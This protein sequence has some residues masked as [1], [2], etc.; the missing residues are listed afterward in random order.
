[1]RRL[2]T[3]TA[4]LLAGL[5]AHAETSRNVAQPLTAA[6]LRDFKRPI[7]LDSPGAASSYDGSFAT[8]ISIP[9]PAARAGFKPTVAFS[10]N[11]QRGN[12]PYARGWDLSL[13]RII[14]SLSGGVPRYFG[15]GASDPTTEDSFDFSSIAG[16]SGRLVRVGSTAKGV[17]YRPER[18]GLFAKFYWTS[19][20]AWRVEHLDGR[21]WEMGD[22]D[23]RDS[24]GT[25]VYGWY[26]KRIRDA[27]GNTIEYAYQMRHG[28]LRINRI[29]Y[30]LH[31]DLSSS[32]AT[33]PTILFNW[34]EA[35]G[36][37]IV[38]SYRK[39]FRAE[40]DAEYISSITVVG[41]SET[42]AATTQTHVLHYS[43]QSGA[44]DLSPNTFGNDPRNWRLLEGVTPHQG[45]RTTFTYTPSNVRLDPQAEYDVSCPTPENLGPG[46]QDLRRDL[47]TTLRRTVENKVGNDWIIREVSRLVDMDGDGD[48]DML[49]ARCANGMNGS[50]S[51]SPSSGNHECSWHWRELQGTTWATTDNSVTMPFNWA[52][53]TCT[54]EQ[55]T[56]DPCRA[57]SLTVTVRTK[58][59]YLTSPSFDGYKATT[60]Q[61][62]RD[63]NGDGLSDLVYVEGVER[64]LNGVHATYA[65]IIVCPNLGNGGFGAC[66][67]WWT[68]PRP[69]EVY[70]ELGYDITVGTSSQ[71]WT[72][73]TFLDFDGDG[74]LDYLRTDVASPSSWF[75]HR[76][77]PASTRTL[78]Q[79]VFV[80]FGP[81][82]PYQLPFRPIEARRGTSSGGSC[83]IMKLVDYNGDG[84]PDLWRVSPSQGCATVNTTSALVVYPGNGNGFDF[85]APAV[86]TNLFGQPLEHTYSKNG[87]F[88]TVPVG[89]ASYTALLDLNGDGRPDWIRNVASAWYQGHYV[90]R[91][92]S[93]HFFVRY[94]TGTGFAA[95]VPLGDP[96][97]FRDYPIYWDSVAPSSRPWPSSYNYIHNELNRTLVWQNDGARRQI[98]FLNST[99]LDLDGD[100]ISSFVQAQE[101]N[102]IY[103][104]W[105]GGFWRYTPGLPWLV[106]PLV[107]YLGTEVARAPHRIN[108]TSN[109]NLETAVEYERPKPGH[110]LPMTQWVAWKLRTTDKVT[111]QER[112]VAQWFE[113]PQYDRTRREFAG[114]GQVIRWTP[115]S[116]TVTAYHQDHPRRGLPHSIS[117]YQ[118]D[119]DVLDGS[120]ILRAT[121]TLHWD[122]K[123]LDA[124]GLRT[125][126]RRTK[127]EKTVYDGDQGQHQRT[128]TTDFTY[129]ETADLLS[130]GLL[131]ERIYAVD[132]ATALLRKD[133]FEYYVYADASNE[134]DRVLLKKQSRAAKK[135][136]DGYEVAAWTQYFY[137]DQCDPS[138][139]PRRGLLCR[140]QVYRGTGE[141]H[142]ETNYD[143]DSYGRLTSRTPPGQSSAQ[144]LTYHGVTSYVHTS[145]MDLGGG[146][147][148]VK[149]RTL[150]HPFA[151]A[152]QRSC[153]PQYIS[154]QAIDKCS[155]TTFDDLGRPLQVRKPLRVHMGQYENGLVAEYSYQDYLVGQVPPY[156]QVTR[157][158]DPLGIHNGGSPR[159]SRMYYGGDGAALQSVQ[160]H[161]SLWVKRYQSFDSNGRVAQS[162]KP[163]ESADSLFEL[164]QQLADSTYIYDALDRTVEVRQL[165]LPSRRVV[166]EGAT[167][168]TFDELDN[169]VRVVRN[170]V[171]EPVRVARVLAGQELART[172]A[173]DGAGR[174][175]EAIDASGGVYA[176]RYYADGQLKRA[177]LPDGAT[178]DYAR[179][180][181]GRLTRL[182]HPH[183]GAV[184][185]SYDT[186]TGRLQ[187]RNVL[188]PSGDCASSRQKTE[189][190]VYGD[191]TT[192]QQL[193]RLVAV[194]SGDYEKT[195]DYD[196]L[197]RRRQS[198]LVDA[199]G[200]GLDV[201]YTHNA[202]GELVRREFEG[203]AIERSYDAVGRL[204]DVVTDS[205]SL[206]ASV[207]YHAHGRPAFLNVTV[208]GES[209]L[210][211][212]RQFQYDETRRLQSM[213]TWLPSGQSTVHY[214][215]YAN[216]QLATMS[217]TLRNL[218][219]SW[220]YDSVS[221]LK[222]ATGYDA[223]VG[224][225]PRTF[226]YDYAPNGS[227]LTVHR[228]QLSTSH[229]YTDA[230]HYRLAYTLH[231]GQHT[232]DFTYTSSGSRCQKQ[233]DGST[234][235]YRWSGDGRLARLIREADHSSPYLADYYYDH[236]GKRWKR[237]LNESV[238]LYLGEMEVDAETEARRV[239]VS[240]PWTKCRLPSSETAGRCYFSDQLN[241]AAAIDEDGSLA[242]MTS[243][244]PYGAEITVSG[245]AGDRSNRFGFNGKQREL[246]GALLYY[247]ARYYD[248]A[249]G[250][251]ISVDPL[252]TSGVKD[253][254]DINSLNPFLFAAADPISKFDPDGNNPLLA[255]VAQVCACERLATPNIM[256]ISF[257][258]LGIQESDTAK[259]IRLVAYQMCNAATGAGAVKTAVK[260][261]PVTLA[262][263]GG[264]KA[265][266]GGAMV[267]FLGTGDSAAGGPSAL[268]SGGGRR[269]FTA[270]LRA[271]ALSLAGFNKDSKSPRFILDV[272]LDKGG[273]MAEALRVAG[274][275]I[276]SV[277]EV[278]GNN[279]VADKKILELARLIG[280][281]VLTA[282]RG[283]QGDGGFFE[284]AV[285]A[286]RARRAHDLARI[287]KRLPPK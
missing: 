44:E 173:Y 199:D 195:F 24:D 72:E 85:S 7:S 43:S 21:V 87:E 271:R 193:G 40:L 201:S 245:D 256:G 237:I 55:T 250:R 86:S 118:N 9:L 125:W 230:K 166:F 211:L 113:R 175:A 229:V 171:G 282:D 35:T 14:R 165:G 169:E 208:N 206:T 149:T 133:S 189:T 30:D 108:K 156:A 280:A 22:G 54:D 62:L 126:A 176:Y 152:A 238:T 65:D 53:S 170:L 216:G 148:E 225:W 89:S 241:T 257:T 226:A 268:P 34:T 281:R 31:S 6:G 246:D 177:E 161:G 75:V 254:F 47:T 19:A 27:I 37:P 198:S 134:S 3:V 159:S 67:V 158:P 263:T 174:I 25:N 253:T 151:D 274:F 266:A 248:P 164:P 93:P 124:T 186:H 15:P 163:W 228:D 70:L 217:D 131:K 59:S 132:T 270:A 244:A 242:W 109:P 104:A 83:T 146:A 213:T 234:T 264:R 140:K 279:A 96:V 2:V 103:D 202:L 10:Y 71:S 122:T 46:Y 63:M 64:T 29:D 76:I 232:A 8:S 283:R 98:R 192:P 88:G 239:Y 252:R 26:A 138:A 97:R 247:G 50:I 119:D 179:D 105:G 58:G 178:W 168:K 137:D 121:K 112:V 194:R 115:A 207:H 261:L 284:M 203:D 68:N 221:R 12:T 214:T 272:N 187:S 16:Q 74:H 79:P 32:P 23:A 262:S 41:Y 183:G 150:Y 69:N 17:L 129:Y 127:V 123:D 188:A 78:A 273:R 162:W 142:A 224:G 45:Q 91:Q 265:I 155:E 220:T 20:N 278:F 135:G 145:R 66:S 99:F 100:G 141:S 11:S 275:N 28:V 144:E 182:D 81:N 61:D 82:L 56:S 51:H 143:Y 235:E 277:R 154:D 286:G 218:S 114:F 180:T 204:T 191:A 73:A 157:Y 185:L 116:T 212:S 184:V 196:P 190:F 106:T 13:P 222:S 205:G 276:R 219:Y 243:Y 200:H 181:A 52:F 287:L 92:P 147:A 77:D 172:F 269:A 251:W 240:L 197:G 120:D 95:E 153:G 48:L 39:G 160:G 101:D 215:H 42:T 80:S 130:A 260:S 102:A 267:A 5:S 210:A 57:G 38:I 60:I 167:T 94:N 209:S 1:M 139:T 236:A 117:V 111:Q 90:T 4:V 36:S 33:S 110:R 136:Q 49:Y 84:I 249:L 227:I 255:K 223:P 128:T 107:P 259:A 258:K 18:E 231:A 285:Q 233:T